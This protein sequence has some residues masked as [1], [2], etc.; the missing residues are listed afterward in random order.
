LSR[1][2]SNGIKH[3]SVRF[4]WSVLEPNYNPSDSS[5][6]TAILSNYKRVLETAQK[7][8]I[9]VNLD[10]WTHFQDV[11]WDMPGYI[12]SI[13]DI[14]RNST[15]KQLWLRYVEAVVTELKDY[16]SVESWAILNE[17][18][19][20][21]SSDRTLLQQLFADETA[22]IKSVDSSHPVICRFS[23]SY[24]PGSGRYDSSIYD[25]FDAF[26]ITE[27]LD[28]TNPSDTKYNARW[29][30]W[31]KTVS[32]CKARNKPLWIIECGDDNPDSEHVRLHYELSLQKFQAAG[33][34]KAFSWAWQTRTASAE[35][36]N[37]YDGT[38]PKP[39]YYEVTKYGR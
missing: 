37:I 23:L 24:T 26:A 5:L 35:S 10:F 34:Q 33:V 11:H 4:I 28:P 8:G 15:A 7:H 38:A 9:G 19:Y 2:A 18:F 36:F 32:D 6:S 1:F 27:Y 21:Y 31:D 20:S 22:T 25:I 13:F 39:A 12:T 29:S 14:I 17:P 16:S 30:Y 3:I